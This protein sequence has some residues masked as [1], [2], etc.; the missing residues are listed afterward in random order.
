MLFLGLSYPSPIDFLHFVKPKPRGCAILFVIENLKI[1]KQTVFAK[2]QTLVDSRT[3][4]IRMIWKNSS[5][6]VYIGSNVVMYI[7]RRR[8]GRIPNYF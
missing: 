5:P 7:Y 6:P 4:T 2:M 8:E 3:F 1:N